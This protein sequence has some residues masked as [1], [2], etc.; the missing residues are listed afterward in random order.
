MY[1]IEYLKTRINDDDI[2]GD[3]ARDIFSDYNLTYEKN[4]TIKDIKTLVK[5]TIA[6][7]AFLESYNE[8]KSYK[9]NKI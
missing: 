2:V 8:Y 6:E 5:G 3:L 9:K 1:Y 7:Q 4:L